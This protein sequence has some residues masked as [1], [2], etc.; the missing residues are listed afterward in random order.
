VLVIAPGPSMAR[1]P[2]DAGKCSRFSWLAWPST[3]RRVRT[4]YSST[5]SGRL[6]DPLFP[7]RDLTCSGGA[8]DA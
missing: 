2:D 7:N 6:I 8:L 1:F 5:F 3:D 4:T